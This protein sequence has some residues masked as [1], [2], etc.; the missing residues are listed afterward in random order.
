MS[1]FEIGNYVVVDD[2]YIG[3]IIKK[4]WNEY[5]VIISLDNEKNYLDPTISQYRMLDDLA[6]NEMSGYMLVKPSNKMR[7]VNIN[8]LA[9]IIE[10]ELTKEL[11]MGIDEKISKNFVYFKSNVLG[12][13]TTNKLMQVPVVV[14]E[15]NPTIKQVET[16]GQALSPQLGQL[17]QAEQLGQ[18]GQLGG[19]QVSKQL[20]KL[21]QWINKEKMSESE[22]KVNSMTSKEKKLFS[23]DKKYQKLHNIVGGVY[24]PY[25]HNVKQT[26]QQ[27]KIPQLVNTW[28]GGSPNI[29]E[30][31]PI[32]QYIT[33]SP[34]IKTKPESQMTNSVSTYKKQ[35]MQEDNYVQYINTMINKLFLDEDI[36]DYEENFND[37]RLYAKEAEELNVLEEGQRANV[38][39]PAI[40][41]VLEKFEPIDKNLYFDLTN[42]LLFKHIMPDNK[43]DNV[44]FGTQLIK[45]IKTILL[46]M[47]Q[48]IKFEDGRN[49]LDEINLFG[50]LKFKISGGYIIIEN[51]S[52]DI[53]NITRTI[54]PELIPDLKIFSNQYGNPINYKILSNVILQNKTV[55]QIQNNKDVVLEALNILAQDYYI[56]LQPK[57][58]YLLWTL[59]RLI[60]CW[61]SDSILNENIFKIKIL[62]NLYR[63]RGV[64]EFNKDIGVQPVIL[65]MPK[66][67]RQCSLKILSQLSYYF[68][69]YKNVGW[70]GS[71]PSYFN[72]VDNLIHYTNG[73]IDLK[74]YIRQLLK[75]QNQIISPVSTDFTKISLPT[76]TNDIEYNL[77]K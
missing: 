69:P 57:A 74:K 11:F 46:S 73:S 6:L 2:K 38:I 36:V 24:N 65:I 33:V 42:T 28:K 27:K 66:Y 35:D 41:S 37:G 31:T 75:T 30:L 1:L 62:I 70:E 51:E 4:V 5:G 50:Y 23:N 52:Y 60:L 53:E 43:I 22:V 16:T 25:L 61:Y 18:S 67:G 54:T 17:G 26:P 10:K 8:N 77:P 76:D 14:N 9:E 15:L 55:E 19:S 44:A 39:K 7:L 45:K 12:N 29:A 32:K 34:Y 56:C 20:S 48:A 21:S 68:F 63:A 40:K 47:Q 58:E 59:T 72:K 64:K 3:K 71:N 49:L 13:I